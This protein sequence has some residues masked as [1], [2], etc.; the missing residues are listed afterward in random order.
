M[1]IGRQ[2]KSQKNNLIAVGKGYN[3]YDQ[4]T[5]E[6]K[7]SYELNKK[8][9][10]VL[11]KLDTIYSKRNHYIKDKLTLDK[12]EELIKRVSELEEEFKKLL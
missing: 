5:A 2:Y 6:L 7:E 12:A 3:R 4:E 1:G 8:W 10:T 11:R 9:N